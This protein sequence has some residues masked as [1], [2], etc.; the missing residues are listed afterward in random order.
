MA[1]S[2]W[3]GG[4]YQNY[5]QDETKL[6]KAIMDSKIDYLVIDCAVP[7][8][9]RKPHH[10]LLAKLVVDHPEVFK[11]IQTE[12]IFREGLKLDQPIRVCKVDRGG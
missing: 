1:A 10:E 2:T 8:N 4:G 12:P 6:M 3:G 5:Y 11:P 9:Y 7:E